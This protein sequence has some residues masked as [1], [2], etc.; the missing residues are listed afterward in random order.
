MQPL[1]HSSSRPEIGDEAKELVKHLNGIGENLASANESYNAALS[2]FERRLIPSANRVA[3]LL[4]SDAV[5]LG[6]M[7]EELPRRIALP[8]ADDIGNQLHQRRQGT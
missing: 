2:S 5:E 6:S 3:A 7:I 8:E 4:A 1:R